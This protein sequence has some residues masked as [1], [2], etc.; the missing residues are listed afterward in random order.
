MSNVLLEEYLR[1]LRLPT[2]ARNYEKAAKEAEGNHVTF[3]EYLC[4]LLEQEVQSRD[5]SRRKERMR[6]AQFPSS[7]TLDNFKFDEIP[8]LDKKAVLQLFR[9]SY[10]HDS[11]NIVFIGPQGTGKTHLSIALGM[12]ACSDGMH[13][14]FH[15]AG[16][17]LHQLIEARDEKQVLKVQQNLARFDLLILDELGMIDCKPDEAYLLFEVISARYEHSSTIIT[18]N[19]EFKDW[20]SVFCTQQLTTA[21]LDRLIHRCHIIQVNGESYRFK[22]SVRRKK[23][24]S[25]A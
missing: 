4:S 10:L 17:L 14:K 22:E 21:L 9:G 20:N 8:A 7:K 11:E 13:V 6:R 23:G 12:Q 3:Q 5:E 19:L 15:T 16:Q 24:K 2:V 18:T 25:A 1:R